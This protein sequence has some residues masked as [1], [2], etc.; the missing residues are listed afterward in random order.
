MP[1]S[2]LR[3]IH[4]V[5][6]SKKPASWNRWKIRMVAILLDKIN[7]NKV[8]KYANVLIFKDFYPKTRNVSY[9]LKSIVRNFS[10]FLI[11]WKIKEMGEQKRELKR[12]NCDLP[13]YCA[14]RIFLVPPPVKPWGTI[15]LH[16]VTLS[17]RPSVTLVFRIFLLHALT[18][19]AEI[20][21][22][23]S[24]YCA[25]EQVRSSLI[26]VNFLW[27]LCPFRY[28]EYR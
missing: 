16:S 28:L 19:W 4:P 18:Y 23:T 26:C 22:M 10:R 24:L 1:H 9:Y 27:E 12:W 20:F 25:T 14:P 11:Y 5:P 17:V 21:H 6:K 3:T 7:N 15:G 2:Q 8:S 13:Y